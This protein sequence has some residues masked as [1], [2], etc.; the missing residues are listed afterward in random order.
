VIF[1]GRAAELRVFRAELVAV[2]RRRSR[3]VVVRGEAGAG[4]TRLIERAQSA[5]N[6]DTLWLQGRGSRLRATSAFALAAEAIESDLRRQP[7]TAVAAACPNRVADLAAILPSVA[8]A[9]RSSSGPP[10]RARVF[11]AL[12]CLLGG[13]ARD[14]AVVLVL[15]DLHDGDPSTWELVDYLARNPID[16]RL[17][18]VAA[19]RSDELSVPA[20]LASTIAALLQDNL[21]TEL[22]V[23]ALGRP[24]IAE[25]AAGAL[26]SL[27]ATAEVVDSLVRRTRG[28]A[29]FVEALLE[30]L[31]TDP[32]RG[33]LPGSI[34]ERV[35]SMTE[36][37]EPR[38]R[39]VLDLAA[40]LGMTFSL[41]AI[42]AVL[43]AG[44]DRVVDQLAALG[45]LKVAT[46]G[47]G[48]GYE[49]AHPLVQEAVYDA[50]G[51]ARR[52]ELHL[53]VARTLPLR[54][55]SAVAYHA[56]LGALPGDA[57]AIDVIRSA[58]TEAERTQ[59]HREA[60]TW[61]RE[62]LDLISRD[63]R[64]LRRD[65]LDSLAAHAAAAGDHRTGVAAIG[66]LLDDARIDDREAG[67]L[68]TRLA[69]FLATGAGDL[70][71]AEREARTAVALLTGGQDGG[72]SRDGANR[73]KADA[74]AYGGPTSPVANALNELGWI[75]GEIGDVAGQVQEAR[76][77]LA[78][79]E[80]D[81]D[82]VTTIH[83][84]GSLGHALGLLGETHDALAIIERSIA[85]AGGEGD[86]AQSDWH[87]GAKAEILTEAGRFLDAAEVVDP[88][89][90]GSDSDTAYAFRARA[91]W[92]LGRWDVARSDCR[93]VQVLH[94]EGPS[95][96]TAWTLSFGGLLASL[97]GDTSPSGPL[98]AQAERAY[99]GRPF[100]WFSAW[101]DWAMG[102]V[103]L[104]GGDVEAACERLARAADRTE[105]MEARSIAVQVLPDLVDALAT[106]G[107][108]R[109]ASAATARLDAL[110]ERLGFPYLRALCGLAHGI[111]AG[112]SRRSGAARSS[113]TAAAAAARGASMPYVQARAL[114]RLAE[115]S[116][117]SERIGALAEA[118]RLYTALPAP[119]DTRRVAASLRGTGRSGAR[120]AQ[121]VGGLTPREREIA[122]LAADRW[123]T[124]EIAERL[125]V[126]DRTVET[127]LAH[128]YGKLGISGREELREQRDR[129]RA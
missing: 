79:A 90:D 41:R 39:D 108:V 44:E 18:V 87:A 115:A 56:A 102:I 94:P 107:L 37:L 66:A 60:M 51:L 89:L 57:W 92:F 77:A 20:E 32:S 59:S 73:R 6:R 26:G 31:A 29:L 88:V 68:R 125:G 122:L 24:A 85:L 86:R 34:A 33:T 64:R 106:L 93:M 45:L 5:A 2:D 63:Q 128:V 78:I 54:P 9:M 21:A 99:A 103:A 101:H 114:E 120:A 36:R 25:L 50:I 116:A 112:A 28:N 40:V 95:V 43:P 80:A 16:A 96:H 42:G 127:H 15:D 12:L 47:S 124:R 117:G 48:A 119:E 67:V 53:R 111:T 11:E 123:T 74:P 70:P 109:E 49:F 97:T 121:A 23:G 84:L 10:S 35:H 105:A 46:T 55:A 118:G 62:I 71:G 65:T 17:L 69:S 8:I 83:A 82:R 1:V 72:V 4:K 27:G 38:A 91:A 129:L 81:G 126:G 52:R 30:D 113:L 19:V 13:L 104:R 100:Y 76:R 98:L 58:A 75:R 14:H 7:P 61:L 22:R 3:L 110:A